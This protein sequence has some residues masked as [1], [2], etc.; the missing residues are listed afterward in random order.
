M[1]GLFRI[2]GKREH[3][4]ESN[5]WESPGSASFKVKLP[6]TD[7]GVVGKSLGGTSKVGA[8]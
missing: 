7:N 3:Q 6:G 4:S 1:E 8:N 2:R 5:P